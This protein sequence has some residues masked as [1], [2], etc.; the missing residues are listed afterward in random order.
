MSKKISGVSL[1]Y[2]SAMNGDMSALET[3]IQKKENVNML[4]IDLLYY[5]GNNLHDLLYFKGIA[6][7]NIDENALPI[8]RHNKK[9]KEMLLNHKKLAAIKI[10]IE[11]GTT[12]H[13]DIKTC[14]NQ[15][16]MDAIAAL[17]H[18]MMI[19]GE[20][21]NNSEDSQVNN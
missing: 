9:C 21:N 7:P 16:L 18:N 4:L 6:T 10:L 2:Q 20:L 14:A 1:L 15:S 17:D 11:H 8:D 12:T 3:L 19:L 13:N 5:N